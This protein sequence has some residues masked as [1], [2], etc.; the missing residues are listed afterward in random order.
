LVLDE[1]L[2]ATG[3]SLTPVIE[4]STDADDVTLPE[5]FIW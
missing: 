2:T 5:S 1:S 3:A 4:M